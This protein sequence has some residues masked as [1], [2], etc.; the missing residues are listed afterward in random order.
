VVHDGIDEGDLVVTRGA[1]QLDSELQIQAKPAMMLQ[2]Q[3]MGEGPAQEA[4]VTISGAWKPILRSLARARESRDGPTEFREHLQRAR[5][6]LE[7]IE[8]DFLPDDYKPLWGEAKMQLGNLFTE[9]ALLAKNKTVTTAWENLIRELPDD[10]ALA[11]LQ[12]QL[13]ELDS[14][15]PERIARLQNALT[16]YLPVSDALS[17]DKPEEALQKLPEL[18]TALRALELMSAATQLSQASDEDSLRTA[19]KPTTNALESL[20]SEGAQDKLGSLYLV[21][22]PMA[23]GGDGANWFSRIPKVENPYYGSSMFD[24]GDVT[25]TLSLPLDEIAP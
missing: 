17:H 22:C 6:I 21:H 7:T 19:L 25:E 1:F 24:C 9:S 13:P 11:G 10:A 8:P 20:I 18:V 15:P 2:G 23:A 14:A 4:P 5:A 16:A 3:D 12:W